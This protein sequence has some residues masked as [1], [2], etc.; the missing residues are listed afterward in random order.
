MEGGGALGSRFRGNDGG[1][2]G[3]RGGPWVPAF[4]GMTEE[5]GAAEEGGWRVGRFGEGAPHSPPSLGSRF[6]GNDGG[7]AGMTEGG[8]G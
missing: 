7:R 2:G 8:R 1:G 4:A 6:R 3:G 5:G